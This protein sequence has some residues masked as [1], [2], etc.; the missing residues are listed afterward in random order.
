M[1]IFKKRKMKKRVLP[2]KNL[3]LL[4]AKI[5]LKIKNKNIFYEALTHKSYLYFHPHHPYNH[6]ER[7]EFLGDAIIEFIIS[8]YLFRKF[9]K[10]Q[11]G[12]LTLIRASLVNRE[13]L[14][15]LAEKFELEKFMFLGE[16]LS[17]KGL[18]TVL[19]NGVE[20]L[21]GAIFLDNDLET[22]KKFIEDNFFEDLGEIIKKRLYKDPKSELQEILQGKY[23]ILPK[24]VVL[25]EEGPSHKKKFTVGLYVEDKLISV[26]EGENKQQAEIV[27]ASKALKKLKKNL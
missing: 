18:K 9:V 14:L 2:D 26:G 16:N 4:E 12:E 24:Y 5:N 19:S 20:A 21:V 10:F 13:R 22:V 27:A 11:E 7:L 15:K 23:K 25:K 3:S 6:N 17:E 8:W 1:K